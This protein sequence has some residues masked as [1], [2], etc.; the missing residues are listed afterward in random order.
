[1]TVNEYRKQYPKCTYC[2]HLAP[3]SEKCRA[4]E[5]FPAPWA[6]KRCPLY[7]PESYERE[8]M[9]PPNVGSGVIAKPWHR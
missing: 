1:M 8:G 4:R 5:F 6:A 7:E 3:G 9:D 2:K